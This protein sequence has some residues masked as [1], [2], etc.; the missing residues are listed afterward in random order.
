MHKQRRQDL[1]NN[2]P[3]LFVSDTLVIKLIY[4]F[5]DPLMV[6]TR[7][8]TFPFRT[9]CE[10]VEIEKMAVAFPSAHGSHEGL[11][12]EGFEGQSVGF[13]CLVL[14][15]VVCQMQRQ[16]YLDNLCPDE[17]SHWSER[18][19]SHFFLPGQPILPQ[20]SLGHLSASIRFRFTKFTVSYFFY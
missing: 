3:T 18:K 20:S 19:R 16:C 12:R 9:V 13:V 15:V 2:K 5:L 14:V 6:P 4:Y 17:S 11:R 10:T 1:T 7:E 8:F